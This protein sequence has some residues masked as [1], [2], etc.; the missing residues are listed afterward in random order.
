MKINSAKLLKGLQD[1]R[2]EDPQATDESLAKKL[3][4]FIETNFHRL[5]KQETSSARFSY[6]TVGYGIFSLPHAVASDF[7]DII[8]SLETELPISI[9]LGSVKWCEEEYAKALGLPGPD[10]LR[11]QETIDRHRQNQLEKYAQSQGFA[12]WEEWQK[13]QGQKPASST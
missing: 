11:D 7:E 3:A 1:I 6:S 9:S 2:K 8:D 4:I 13:T 12:S 5:V 10:S